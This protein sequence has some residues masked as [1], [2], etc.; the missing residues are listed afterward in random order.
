[1]SQ[2]CTIDIL[3]T[4]LWECEARNNPCNRRFGCTQTKL[5]WRFKYERVQALLVLESEGHFMEI[6]NPRYFIAIA[7]EKSLS[8]AASRIFISQSSLS[9]YIT[10]V[11]E[12]IGTR[13]LDRLPNGVEL[14]PAGEKYLA[15]CRSIIDISEKLSEEISESSDKGKLSVVTTSVWGKRALADLVPVFLMQ[16]PDVQIRVSQTPY[17]GIGSM[18]DSKEADFALITWSPYLPLQKDDHLLYIEPLLFAV[19]ALHPL[20]DTYSQD[21][22]T[23]A[24]IAETFRS[25]HFILS[26]AAG[27]DHVTVMHAFSDIGFTPSPVCESEDPYLSRAL[28]AAGAG[29]AFIPESARDSDERI[30]Y[31]AVSNLVRYN[32]LTCRPLKNFTAYERGFFDLVMEYFRS[33]P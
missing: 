5:D 4:G 2:N 16:H 20:A 3:V 18:I 33:R 14:T 15:A 6:K 8:R 13:L 9:Y 28:V 17:A 12:S 27:A 11:E 1:M 24:Q 7:E 25:E 29:V 10:S 19:P 30:R 32:L 26:G 31:Y 22:L 23:M 21:T